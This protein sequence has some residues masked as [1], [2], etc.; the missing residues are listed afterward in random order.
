MLNDDY[1]YRDRAEVVDDYFERTQE[2]EYK[3][4]I[5]R[6]VMTSDALE[7]LHTVK[8]ADVDLYKRYRNTLI[9]LYNMKVIGRNSIDLQ[10]F[11]ETMLQVIKFRRR[12]ERAS[13]GRHIA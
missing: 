7:K 9:N 3:E 12:E 6:Y 1:S 5:L 8:I 2:G 4:A 11:R 13:F 10:K